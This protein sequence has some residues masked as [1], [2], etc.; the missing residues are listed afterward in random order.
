M[1]DREGKGYITKNDICR[2]EQELPEVSKDQLEVVFDSLDSDGNGSLTLDEFTE[3]FGEYSS[4]RGKPGVVGLAPNWVRLAP[5]GTNPGLFQIRF[6]CI[7][8][9]GAKCTEI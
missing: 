5:N 3:G 1:C 9:R 6:Q 2:L 7:W 8:R 4:A